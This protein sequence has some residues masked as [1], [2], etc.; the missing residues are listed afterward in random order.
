MINKS[1][2]LATLVAISFIGCKK[3]TLTGEVKDAFTGKPL[4]GALPQ[5]LNS[6]LRA[7]KPTTADGK[8]SI[9]EIKP[10]KYTLRTGR[11]LSSKSKI[12]FE[13]TEENLN[14][15]IEVFLYETP[16]KL[17]PGLYN[18]GEEGPSKILNQWAGYNFR[19]ADNIKGFKTS[20]LKKKLPASAEQVADIDV[21]YRQVAAGGE[22]SITSAPI[23]K[24]SLKGLKDCVGVEKEKTALIADF[25]KANTFET[26]YVSEGLVKVKGTLPKGPQML[27]AVE[28][29]RTTAAY[30]FDVK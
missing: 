2:C 14:P 30:Y 21:F 6:A 29:Q 18:K 13:V 19:C 12:E 23:A 27:I 28:G 4:D 16:K 15:T 9:A 11:N 17:K 25:S 24:K 10:G 1:L 8:F 20:Y 7:E 3:G 22:V 26:S 5:I